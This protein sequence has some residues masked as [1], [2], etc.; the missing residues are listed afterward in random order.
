MRIRG[1]VQ[2]VWFRDSTRREAE[3]LGIT[4]YA[5]NLDSGDV[6]VLACGSGEALEALCAWLRQGPPLA[7]VT[8][9]EEKVAEYQDLPGFTIG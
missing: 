2:G 5:I 7:K 9:I 6:E 4:G 8:D 3:Q 1:R